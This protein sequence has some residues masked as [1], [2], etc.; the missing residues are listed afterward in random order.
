[1][2]ASYV[3]IFGIGLSLK[4]IGIEMGVNG[5]IA[6]AGSFVAASAVGVSQIE[7]ISPFYKNRVAKTLDEEVITDGRVVKSD[8]EFT[9]FIKNLE[10][11][12]SSIN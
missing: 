6:S 10:K 2:V 9:Q 1:V 8:A 4:A 11:A 7:S 3:G 5:M 12:L